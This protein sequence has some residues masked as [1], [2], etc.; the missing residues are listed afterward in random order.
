MIPL[1]SFL[2]SLHLFSGHYIDMVGRNSMFIPYRI[3]APAAFIFVF[4]LLTSGF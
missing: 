1:D 2:C 3:K 4:E